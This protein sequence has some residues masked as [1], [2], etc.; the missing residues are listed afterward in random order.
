MSI[1]FSFV[2]FF[3][4]AIS[5]KCASAFSNKSDIFFPPNRCNWAL[6]PMSD[7]CARASRRMLTLVGEMVLRNPIQGTLQE[8][9]WNPLLEGNANKGHLSPADRADASSK[10]SCA[11]KKFGGANPYELCD[12]KGSPNDGPCVYYSFGISGEVAFETELSNSWK[13]KGYLLDPTVNYKAQIDTWSLFFSIGANMLTKYDDYARG[14]IGKLQTS[15]DTVSL[16]KLQNFLGHKN[17][18][19]VK[20]DCEGCEYAIARDVALVSSVYLDIYYFY[21]L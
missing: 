1:F 4:S 9:P 12:V 7:L 5:I 20:M 21:F 16:P 2:L 3:F 6:D 19:L 8:P 10:V 15:W 14:R 13:C 17:I 18:N 11:I